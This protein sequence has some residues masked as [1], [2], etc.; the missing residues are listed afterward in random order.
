LKQ[1]EDVRRVRNAI[2]SF[3]NVNRPTDEER[4]TSLDLAAVI[5]A[6]PTGIE[7]AAELAMD[8]VEQDGPSTYP[9]EI[10]CISRITPVQ[11][12]GSV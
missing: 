10:V 1:V 6:G 7:F 8:F 4:K 12:A 11:C 5:G 3:S 9:T 2:V